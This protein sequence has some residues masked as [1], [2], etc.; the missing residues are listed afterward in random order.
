MSEKDGTRRE[1][2]DLMH[3]K[4]EE[5]GGRILQWSKKDVQEVSRKGSMHPWD[6][7]PRENLRKVSW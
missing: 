1:S 6:K 5:L 3:P 4:Y 7:K 2:M